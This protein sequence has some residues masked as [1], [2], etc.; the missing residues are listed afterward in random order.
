[1][2]VFVLY[3]VVAHLI[4]FVNSRPQ[5]DDWR[6]LRSAKST[7][8]FL[9]QL[10]NFLPQTLDSSVVDDDPKVP[11]E[12]AIT[13]RVEQNQ[14]DPTDDFVS[15][16]GVELAFPNSR[17]P[18]IH[19]DELMDY[20][21]DEGK[22]KEIDKQAKQRQCIKGQ[23]SAVENMKRS[24]CPNTMPV[25]PLIPLEDPS[26]VQIRRHRPNLRLEDNLRLEKPIMDPDRVK[27][28]W[29][30]CPPDF[31]AFCCKGPGR[32]ILQNGAAVE[33]FNDC[34]FPSAHVF[35]V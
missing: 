26:E 21:D 7:N 33:D 8:A 6:S 20:V 35:Q 4:A 12:D 32:E 24:V 9:P 13:S 19:P 1:M 23:G 31:R 17:M 11:V 25:S 34:M 16:S 29:Y 14:K 30:F 10:P 28:T 18:S 27:T 2:F 22:D 3:P 15:S 5:S